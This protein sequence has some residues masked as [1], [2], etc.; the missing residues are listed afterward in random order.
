AVSLLLLS[1]LDGKS[2]A[3]SLVGLVGALTAVLGAMAVMDKYSITGTGTKS[4]ITIVAMGI[5][6]MAMAGAMKKLSELNAGEITKGVLAMAGMMGALA[7]AMTL[8][9]KFGGAKVGAS[10]LQ[11]LAIARAMHL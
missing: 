8:M 5:A 9:S 3:N 11:I 7:G 1:T 6:M 2:I 10:S 4:A